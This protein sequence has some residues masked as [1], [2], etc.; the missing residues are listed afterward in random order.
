MSK[1][2]FKYQSDGKFICSYKNISQAAADLRVNESSIRKPL[3]WQ[4][5]A[6]VKDYYFSYSKVDNFFDTDGKKPKKEHSAKILVLDIETAPSEAFIWKIWKEN[7]GINQIIDDWYILSYSCKW[8]L[9]PTTYSSVL[10][11]Q[12]AIMRD[13]S[14]LLQELWEWLD[15]A[16][17]VIAHNCKGFDI[18]S[19][20]TRFVYHGFNPTSSFQMI[21]TLDVCRRNFRF[22]SNKLDYVT[23]FVGL[24]G[25]KAHEGFDMWAKCVRG[26]EDTL[27]QMEQY[28]RQD[29]TEL[30]DLYM[31]LRPWVKPHPNMGLFKDDGEVGCPSCGSTN[32]FENGY[33][34]TPMNKYKEFHCKSC[35]AVGRSRHA[36]K[37]PSNLLSSTSH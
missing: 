3:N 23:Q 30:E 32:I 27:S 24:N 34:Y 26:D 28:N 31:L 16:D 2:V 18:P 1:T 21:D 13:D 9:D 4:N 7:I 20:N 25:K 22:T 12:E 6:K 35:G 10:T 14:R 8:L 11:T 36:E 5:Y 33:Y 29:V 15:E 17:V 19:I 37:K